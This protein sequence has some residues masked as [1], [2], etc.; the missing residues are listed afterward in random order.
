MIGDT[1]AGIYHMSS[2]TVYFNYTYSPAW[3]DSFPPIVPARPKFAVWK[4]KKLYPVYSAEGRLNRKYVLR[5][6]E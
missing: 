6:S 2:D 5:Y 1:S 4:K 3:S